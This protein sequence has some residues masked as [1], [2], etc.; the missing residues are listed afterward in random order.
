MLEI[1]FK[2]KQ[3]DFMAGEEKKPIEE[4]TNYQNMGD[5]E[6]TL[7][8]EEQTPAISEQPKK[9]QEENWSQLTPEEQQFHKENILTPEM[10]ETVKKQNDLLAIAKRSGLNVEITKKQ[11]IDQMHDEANRENHIFDAA[12]DNVQK[13]LTQIV[14]GQGTAIN[15]DNNLEVIEKTLNLL[16]ADLSREELYAINQSSNNA[17][18]FVVGNNTFVLYKHGIEI[19]IKLRN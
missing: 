1:N 18:E 16:G 8:Q 6:S 4:Q 17:K 5:P 7:P 12:R 3:G 19:F 2:F 13:I 14:E 9:T 10:P 11:I 15:L